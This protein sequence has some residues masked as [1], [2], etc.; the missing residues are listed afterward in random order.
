MPAAE[1]EISDGLVEALLVEQ[2]PDLAH[3]GLRLLANGWDNV[4]YRL[5]AELMV[6]LPRRQVAAELV[7]NEAAW[8]PLL[9]PS[10]PIPV[11]APVRVGRPTASY[12][13]DWTILPYFPGEAV[14]TAPFADPGREAARLGAFLAALHQP[15]PPDAPVNP[16]FRGAPLAARNPITM[17]HMESL[18]DQI[19]LDVVRPSW[20]AA[21]AVTPWAGAPMWLHGDLHPLNM[22]QH[23]GKLAAIIDFG[24]MTGGDPATDLLAA[25]QLFDKPERALLRAAADSAVRPIDDDMWERGRGWAIA[26]ALAILADGADA[27]A[28]TAIALR[29]LDAVTR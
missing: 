4:L 14:G 15:S 17:K 28:L 26:H 13:W 11:P 16:F 7:R 25:W 5:G 6:R 29:T 19:D 23:D 10:L 3:L 24:D 18:A 12:P 27:T 1:V 22:V 2:H 8:L 21:C 20:L 9:A